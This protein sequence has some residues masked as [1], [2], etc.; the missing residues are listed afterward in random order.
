MQQSG[1]FAV[2]PA[3]P[4]LA[5]VITYLDPTDFEQGATEV[6]P[7]SHLQGEWETFDGHRITDDKV[8]ADAGVVLAADAGDVAIVHVQVLHRA[9]H[10]YTNTA[11]HAII[12]EYKTAEAVDRWNNRC[13]LA[14]LPLARNRRLLMPRV[15]EV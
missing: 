8:G 4:G 14:G 5:A 7:G 12:N 3:E 11:R 13:A 2:A 10:N 6:V 1:L 9:G 15:A